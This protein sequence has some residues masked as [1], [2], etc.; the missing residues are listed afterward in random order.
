M[1]RHG[2]L[3]Y[4]YEFWHYSKGDA[5]AEHLG[6]TGAPGK[7][8]PVTV[9]LATGRVEPIVD[10]KT[11]LHTLEQIQHH[12]ELALQRCAAREDTQETG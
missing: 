7:Y 9:D 3:A 10:A 5:Y 8:G 1:A 11:P 12:L 6:G 2:F 4:P